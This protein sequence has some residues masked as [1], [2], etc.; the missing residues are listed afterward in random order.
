M[1]QKVITKCGSFD[2]FSFQSWAEIFIS[3]M[4]KVYFKK[5]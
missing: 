2:N 1:G 4:S 5:E 3:K